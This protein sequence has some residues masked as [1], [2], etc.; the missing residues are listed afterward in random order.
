[1]ILYNDFLMCSENWRKAFE[2]GPILFNLVKL[3]M[4]S[5]ASHFLKCFN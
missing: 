3:G 5:S 4:I 1:M 2:L